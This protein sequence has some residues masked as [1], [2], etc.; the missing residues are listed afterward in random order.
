MELGWVTDEVGRQPWIVYNVITSQ[1]A[2]NYSSSFLIPGILIIAF[3][4]ILLPLTFYFFTRV[5][6]SSSMSDGR[7]TKQKGA[8]RKGGVNY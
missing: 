8:N 3:Y 1:Q 6:N 7:G 4:L 5:F 2:A